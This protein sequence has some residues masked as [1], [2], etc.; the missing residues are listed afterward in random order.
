MRWPLSSPAF[1]E[2]FQTWFSDRSTGEYHLDVFHDPHD[3]D[4]WVCRR[5][6]TIRLPYDELVRYSPGGIPFMTPEVALLF[7]AKHARDKDCTD[8]GRV[9]PHFDRNQ[10]QWLATNLARLHP[11]HPWLDDL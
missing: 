6:N 7:K 2:H 8:F 5:D 9:R 10:V 4:T 1:D 11:G 3:G